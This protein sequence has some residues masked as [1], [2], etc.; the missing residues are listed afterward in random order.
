MNKILVLVGKIQ[1]EN[2]E[3]ENYQLLINKNYLSVEY[4]GEQ[5]RESFLAEVSERFARQVV[6][7]DAEGLLGVFNGLRINDEG[8]SE[9][10]G[11]LED[12]IVRRLG[13]LLR[14]D[15]TKFALCGAAIPAELMN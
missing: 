15:L 13:E 4:S 6:E 2:R 9:K 1:T 5:E 14:N 12:A 7:D 3:C 8:K 10:I 11:R